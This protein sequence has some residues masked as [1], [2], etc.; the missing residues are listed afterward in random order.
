MPTAAEQPKPGSPELSACL[1]C[2]PSYCGLQQHGGSLTSVL[3]MRSSAGL[4]RLTWR[5]QEKQQCERGAR[6]LPPHP[7]LPRKG[8]KLLLW[9]HTG[10]GVSNVSDCC[11]GRAAPWCSA[12]VVCGRSSWG[13]LEDTAPQCWPWFHGEQERGAQL[14]LDPGR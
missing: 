2:E 4:S 7:F 14:V 8:T 11:G 12:R 10:T 1:P 13:L 6:L 3:T 5:R 9:H